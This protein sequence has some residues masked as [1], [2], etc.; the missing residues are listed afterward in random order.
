M[1]LPA[2]QTPPGRRARGQCIRS[3][4]SRFLRHL[5]PCKQEP[6]EI[7]RSDGLDL[8]AQAL[9]RI[10]VDAGKQSAVAPLVVIDSL[11]KPTSQNGALDLQ[12]R[13]RASDRTRLKAQRCGQPGLR[14]WAEA[15]QPAA[16]DFDHC[17]LLRPLGLRQIYVADIDTEF[18]RSGRDE[19]LQ[20]TVLEPLLCGQP[21]FLRHAPVMRRDRAIGHSLR[22]F[23]GYALCHAARVD[24]PQ[25][26]G[27]RQ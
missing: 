18:E 14:Y 13:E 6:E 1:R 26:S 15:L 25:Q 12:S 3:L 27:R 2:L 20:L 9:D 11:N 23:M 19:R 22:Q 10:M 4:Q 24:Q 17:L 5:L 8:G 21:V 16:Q 7:A